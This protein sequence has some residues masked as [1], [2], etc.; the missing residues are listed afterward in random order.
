MNFDRFVAIMLHVHPDRY[1]EATSTYSDISEVACA[2]VAFSGN[3]K[4]VNVF[5]SLPKPYSVSRHQVIVS[6]TDRFIITELFNTP[7]EAFKKYLTIGLGQSTTT[8]NATTT[9]GITQLNL[10]TGSTTTLFTQ[11]N[12]TLSLVSFLSENDEANTSFIVEENVDFEEYS[13]PCGSQQQETRSKRPLSGDAPNDTQTSTRRKKQR[14]R[15]K[16]TKSLKG[17]ERAEQH[18]NDD[19]HSNN[20]QSNNDDD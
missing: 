1:V 14:T 19:E 11:T 4:M 17:K 12:R 2:V 8:S 13:I 15:Q 6:P 20:E 5:S 3:T 7:P 16:K 10:R 18:A 9:E